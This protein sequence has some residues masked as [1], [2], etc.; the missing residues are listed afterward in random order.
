[1]DFVFD[2][3]KSGYMLPFHHMPDSCHSEKQ[4]VGNQA[5]FFC[6]GGEYKGR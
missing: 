5:Q 1:M 2:I 3:I 6:R 4:Q